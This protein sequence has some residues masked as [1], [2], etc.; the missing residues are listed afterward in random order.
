V[1][2]DRHVLVTRGT[3]DDRIIV[4]VPEV[5][6]RET[7]G[8]T[9]L[10]VL[11]RDRLPPDVLRG[12][13]Q[14]YRNRYAAVRD[15]VCETEPELREDLLATVPIVDLLTDSVSDIANRLRI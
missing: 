1:A 3:R 9:L 15:A 8:I 7:V 10:H 11:L 6:D 12:V 14:G 2:V 4:L 13:L 5:K